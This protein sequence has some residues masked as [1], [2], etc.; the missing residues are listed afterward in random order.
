M[1]S[2]LR[3]ASGAY[4][5]HLEQ[6]VASVNAAIKRAISREGR[7]AALDRINRQLEERLRARA[8]GR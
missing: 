8:N 4:R 7:D 1:T 3:L 6:R 5:D 2:D